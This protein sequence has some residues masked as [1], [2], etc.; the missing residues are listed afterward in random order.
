MKYCFDLSNS[1]DA[2]RKEKHTYQD[3][4][5]TNLVRTR[6]DY[7]I[8]KIENIVYLVNSPIGF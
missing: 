3:T 1:R 7:V 4:N 2:K 6:F 5:I 8:P